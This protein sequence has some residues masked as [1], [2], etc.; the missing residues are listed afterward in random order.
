[1]DYFAALIRNSH[2]R[3]RNREGQ[4]TISQYLLLHDSE[5]NK[6]TRYA[7]DALEEK[8]SDEANVLPITEDLKVDAR[9][10]S[11]FSNLIMYHSPHSL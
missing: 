4:E 10:T 1:M 3:Q 9:F 11:I 5:W 8:K 6:I 2:I 7:L